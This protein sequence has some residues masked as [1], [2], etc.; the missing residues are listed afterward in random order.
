MDNDKFILGWEQFKELQKFLH[1]NNIKSETLLK[2]CY[3]GRPALYAYPLMVDKKVL[4]KIKPG[5]PQE[6]KCALKLY[7]NI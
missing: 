4:I 3:N 6:L 2:Y 7:Q 1:D 5:M